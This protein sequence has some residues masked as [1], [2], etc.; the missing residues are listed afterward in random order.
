MHPT[1]PLRSSI[2]V[3]RLGCE[4]PMDGVWILAREIFGGFALFPLEATRSIFEAFPGFAPVL[5]EGVFAIAESAPAY[6]RVL[7]KEAAS[8]S[9]CADARFAVFPRASTAIDGTFS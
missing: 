2:R 3:E 9:P 4:Y 8:T 5:P 6:V 7:Q 1:Q